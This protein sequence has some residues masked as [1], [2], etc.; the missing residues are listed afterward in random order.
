MDS[1][2][3]DV[4]TCFSEIGILDIK[5][6][7]DSTGIATGIATITCTRYRIQIH[8]FQLQEAGPGRIL[9]YADDLL[10]YKHG[11]NRRDMINGIQSNLEHVSLW[12]TNYKAVIN[13]TKANIVW[14]SLNNNIVADT[15]PAATYMCINIDR[16]QTMKYLGITFDRSLSFAKHVDDVLQKTWKGVSAVEIMASAEMPQRTLFQ[17]MQAV[18]YLCWTMVW[19][20]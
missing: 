1:N 18:Y 7:N 6:Q 8:N 20:Y 13:P 15:V 17:M 16:E 19:V 3:A 11:R 14:F 12:C 9:T 2:G 10:L 5:D 4:Q